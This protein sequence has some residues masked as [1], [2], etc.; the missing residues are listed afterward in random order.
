M[1]YSSND[2]ISDFSQVTPTTY[3]FNQRKPVN[4]TPDY[5]ESYHHLT[6]YTYNLP[7]S[8]IQ[9]QNLYFSNH[10][11]TLPTKRKSSEV[12]SGSTTL[13]P[14]AKKRSKNMENK[15]CE[16]CFVSASGFHY[17]AYTCEACKLFFVRTA[18]RTRREQCSLKNCQI[19]LET[20]SDCSDC[21]FTKCIAVGMSL[22][23][24]SRYGR[25]KATGTGSIEV[26]QSLFNETKYRFVNIV[27]TAKESS[28]LKNL[29]YLI[30]AFYIDAIAPL[31]PISQLHNVSRSISSVVFFSI[32]F[33]VSI[34]TLFRYDSDIW[35][36]DFQ[37]KGTISFL[38]SVL[39]PDQPTFMFKLA[40]FIYV[41]NRV[42]NEGN[43]NQ[44]ML[45][46]L[47]ETIRS[48]MPV[49]VNRSMFDGSQNSSGSSSFGSDSSSNRFV[50]VIN[51]AE[52]ILFVLLN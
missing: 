39:Y 52:R 37:L 25:R 45:E 40:F 10:T 15:K 41:I 35:Q 9:D 23:G 49:D 2:Y 29:E 14:P 30:Q 13:T 46:I 33:D 12:I 34:E 19:A 3:K 48:E 1:F 43:S 51:C 42:S 44:G 8:T 16:V 38:Y 18:K 28:C 50:D 26:W 24:R 47:K 17:G 31:T 27:Y 32:L 6:A 21:R 36:L 20:R 4:N 5:S 22:T 7:H 11:P